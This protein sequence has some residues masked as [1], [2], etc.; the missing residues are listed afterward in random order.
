MTV[1]T[2]YLFNLNVHP[3]LLFNSRLEHIWAY[4]FLNAAFALLVCLVVERDESIRILEARPLVRVG[5][6]S[7]GLYV[8]HAPLLAVMLQIWPARAGWVL[9]PVWLLASIG[10]ALL[11][12]RFF[13]RPFLRLKDRRAPST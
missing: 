9:L 2:V 11:S 7:Y 12:F 4:S 5:E 3:A 1:V 8:V 10:L 13:E 6:V